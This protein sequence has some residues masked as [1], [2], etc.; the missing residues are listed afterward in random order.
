MIQFVA[1]LLDLPLYVLETEV[2]KGGG[3]LADHH[4]LDQMVEKAVRQNW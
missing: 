3:L 1:V 4:Q 2:K